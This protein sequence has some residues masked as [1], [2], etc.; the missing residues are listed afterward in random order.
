MICW[1]LGMDNLAPDARISRIGSFCSVVLDLDAYFVHTQSAHFSMLLALFRAWQISWC[2]YMNISHIECPPERE[3]KSGG[4]D[5]FTNECRIV[6]N[7][8]S[9]VFG[10]RNSHSH[11]PG[12]FSVLAL[13]SLQTLSTA[14]ALKAFRGL[15]YCQQPFFAKIGF[16]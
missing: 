10:K 14:D 13:C 2:V 15:V 5:S 1:T 11:F 6:E 4:A 9:T 12:T 3:T 8:N 16:L 7:D